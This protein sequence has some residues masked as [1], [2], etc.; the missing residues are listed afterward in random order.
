VATD[1]C[2][3]ETKNEWSTTFSS[4][5]MPF[6]AEGEVKFAFTLYDGLKWLADCAVLGIQL[7]G[8][9]TVCSIR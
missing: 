3:D 5:Y 8:W 9:L 6:G 4:P 2:S 1:K 7:N